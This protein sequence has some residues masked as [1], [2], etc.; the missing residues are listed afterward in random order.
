ML[1]YT[2]CWHDAPLSYRGFLEPVEYQ[3]ALDAL[4]ILDHLGSQ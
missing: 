3:E 1:G 2:R 4:G